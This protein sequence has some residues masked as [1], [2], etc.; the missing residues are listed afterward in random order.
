MCKCRNGHDVSRDDEYCAICGVKIEKEFNERCPNCKHQLLIN[1]NFCPNCGIHIKKHIG[2]HC[3]KCGNKLSAGSK[4][5]DKCGTKVEA[6]TSSNIE[7][8]AVSSK[9]SWKAAL[10]VSIII[11]IVAMAGTALF[12]IM[13]G[14]SAH[15]D[16]NDGWEEVGRVYFSNEYGVT[17]VHK[18]AEKQSNSREDALLDV[19]KM[20]SFYSTNFFNVE[21]SFKLYVKNSGGTRT[22]ELRSNKYAPFVVQQGNFVTKGGE[23]FNARVQR[24][25]SYSYFNIDSS[26]LLDVNR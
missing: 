3:P 24:E 26:M 12:F 21:S 8:K 7:L 25:G 17:D 19:K 11:F 2:I 22:F 18:L 6:I 5:C 13:Q 1:S 23:Y 10:V 14:L 20:K 15:T 16:S 4:F 9:K